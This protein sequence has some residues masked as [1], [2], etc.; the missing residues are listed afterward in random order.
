MLR[1]PGPG[2]GKGGEAGAPSAQP[3]LSQ[4]CWSVP[5]ALGDETRPGA[6]AAATTHHLLMTENPL[7]QPA[8]SDLLVPF[9]LVG[10]TKQRALPTGLLALPPGGGLGVGPLPSSRAPEMTFPAAASSA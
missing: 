9:S 5:G 10:S 3:G 1:A 4:R 2:Q 6:V 7:A 8:R